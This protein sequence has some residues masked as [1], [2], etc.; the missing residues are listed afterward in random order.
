MASDLGLVVHS[1]E[2]DPDEFAPECLGDRFADRGLA[3]AGWSDQ[4][5]DRAVG[6]AVRLG[7]ALLA[8]FPH[9]HEL[10]D[11]ALDIIETG[12]IGVQH[13]A[14]VGRVELLFR[15][16]APRHGNQPVEVAADHR[17]LAGLFA[18]AFEPPQ[19]LLG[20]FPDR[21]RHAGLGDLLL[22]LL[23]QAG[24]VVTEF[25]ADRLH[26]LAQEVLALLLL[27]AGLDVVA[28]LAADL[29]LGQTLA[30]EL[31]RFL[32]AGGHV[33]G[34][35]QFELLVE[36][37]VGAEPG[38]VGQLARL[39]HVAQEVDDPAVGVPQFEDLL[40][41]RPVLANQFLR[42]VVLGVAVV[43]FLNLDPER[44]GIEFVRVGDSG[45]AAPQADHGG[46]GLAPG[47]VAPLD[48]VGDHADPGELALA[49]GQ[50]E[51]LFLVTDVDRKRRRDRGENHCFIEW[52][53]QKIH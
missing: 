39:G 21:F 29:K 48:H 17:A 38:G 45:E 2:R 14:G 10:G 4:G 9:G 33:E 13:F 3:R 26:L 11:P 50:Q 20:L 16:L 15:A 7:L 5:Q 51:D 22:V 30:L 32:E 19:L 44:I 27:G 42:V 49:A 28:D 41:D 23:D 24:V 8:E 52:N 34:V 12:V 37:E 6:P 35:E 31:D 47:R 36:A 53:Q 40:D 43:D 1:A 46:D 18:L 25:L